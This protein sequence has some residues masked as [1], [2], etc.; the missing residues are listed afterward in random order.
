MINLLFVTKS[1]G[2]IA[3]YIRWLVKGLERGQFSI[4]VLCLSEN[5]REFAEELKNNHKVH[6]LSYDM[7]RYR[8]DPVSDARLGLFLAR[9]LRTGGF[10]VIHAHGSKAGFLTR[11]AAVGTGLPVLYSPHCFAFHDYAAPAAIFTT[12]LLEKLAAGWTTKFVLVSEGERQLARRHGIGREEQFVVVHTGID[13]SPYR[14]PA[15]VAQKEALALPASAPVIGSIGRL[16][17]QKSPADFVRMAAGIHQVRPDAQFVWIGDGP[18]ESEIRALSV[19]LGIESCLHLLGR[20]SDVPSLMQIF[21]CLV[22]TSR[23]EGLPL[24]I[25]EA[26]S[27]GIPVVATDIPGTREIIV[28]GR[29]GLLVPV[30]DTDGLT[31]SVLDLL[32]DP[33]MQAEFRADGWRR[34]TEEFTVMHMLSALQNLYRRAASQ[35][36]YLVED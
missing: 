24:V 28:S 12:S 26:L 17:E 32:A 19:E 20:R 30:G 10:D 8:V 16:G 9:L 3:E 34:I 14:R 36:E 18:L 33:S 31:R 15:N 27:A 13:P 5:G 23:W 25:L 1:T 7:K 35:G 6:A 22:L 21:D 2:G 29:N 4:T 11:L